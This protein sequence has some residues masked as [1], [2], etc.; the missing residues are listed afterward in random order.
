MHENFRVLVEE[1][2]AEEGGVELLPELPLKVAEPIPAAGAEEEAG[3]A[4]RPSDLTL[5]DEVKAV[6]GVAG[7]VGK[8][9]GKVVGAAEGGGEPV[10]VSRLNK[11]NAG[12]VKTSTHIFI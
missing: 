5:G 7:V 11:E 4:T 10:A 2:V 6:V 3:V 1:L 8:V 12:S 9:A